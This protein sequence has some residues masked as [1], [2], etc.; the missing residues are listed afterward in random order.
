MNCRWRN[1]SDEELNE[2]L[3][4]ERAIVGLMLSLGF[5][6]RAKESSDRL[7]EINDELRMR[8]KAD[9]YRRGLTLIDYDPKRPM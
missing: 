3:V 8:A 7:G 1:C 2:R 6:R 4:E 5:A 9:D